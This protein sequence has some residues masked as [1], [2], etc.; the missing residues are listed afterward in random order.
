[1]CANAGAVGAGGRANYLTPPVPE[2]N[3]HLVDA[4][5]TAHAGLDVQRANVLPV[6]LQEGDEEVG[7]LVGVGHNVV[8]RHLHVGN[9]NSEGQHLFH[10][11]FD[12][13]L[14]LLALARHAVLVVED[15]REL[16]SLVKARAKHAR[17]QL[18]NGR[19][20]EEDVVG[21]GYPHVEKA[22]RTRLVAGNPLQQATYAEIV[23]AHGAQGWRFSAE[24]AGTR[25]AYGKQNV[26]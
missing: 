7:A 26:L 12:G 20:G 13:G 6:L 11:E 1:V 17:D 2:Y 19:R 8:L 25:Y 10:L 14:E 9:G 5:G 24:W 18:D 22:R 15:G 4:H 21:L 16:A 23:E 3:C